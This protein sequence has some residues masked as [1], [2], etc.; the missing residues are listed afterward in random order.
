MYRENAGISIRG[1]GGAAGVSANVSRTSTA[2][3]FWLRMKS[4]VLFFFFFYLASPISSITA[5]PPPGIKLQIRENAKDVLKDLG[6]MY[7]KGLVNKQFPIDDICLPI[8]SVN[9]TDLQVDP[10]KVDFKFQENI[11]VQIEIKDMNF[12]LEIQREAKVPFTQ[13]KIIEGT[14]TLTAEGVTATITVRMNQNPQGHLNVE[15]PRDNCTIKADTIRT[16]SSGLTGFL[17]DSL[18]YFR[19]YLYLFNDKICPALQPMINNKL[20]DLPMMSTV[21]ED[22]QLDLDYSLS[23]DIEVTSSSLDISFKG[24]LSVH[25]KAVDPGSI[26][27]GR[28][29]VFTET[30]KMVYVGISEFFFNGAAMAI[31][32]SGPFEFNVPEMEGLLV[33]LGQKIMEI[34]P[35]PW[36][37]ELIEA[38]IIEISNDDLSATAYFKAQRKAKLNGFLMTCRF[39]MDIEFKERLLIMNIQEPKC[40][41]KAGKIKGKFLAFLV[42]VF[43]ERITKSLVKEIPIPLPAELSLINATNQFEEG[44]LVVGGSLT[45]NPQNSS[46]AGG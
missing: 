7:L 23:S 18:Q 6:L 38:P 30:N 26:R 4:C 9:L 31:Y 43:H 15:I 42:N 32:K 24:L 33:G 21:Y 12:S 3:G 17:L 14:T 39:K 20:K 13:I 34:K 45:F 16:T 19:L 36:T 10:A 41:E 22:H 29:P 8:K 46:N 5:P 37:A 27:P 11:G 35:G 25:G 28:E 2:T 1:V 44:Y 40:K